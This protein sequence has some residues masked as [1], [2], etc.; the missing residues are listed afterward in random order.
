MNPNRDTVFGEVRAMLQA[1]LPVLWPILIFSAVF[2]V[3]LL[4][5]SFFMLLVYD[6]VLASRSGAT[7]A[8]LLLMVTIAYVFQGAVDVIRSRVLLHSG[9][10]ADQ[11]LCDRLYDIVSRYEQEVGPMPSGAAPVR[12]LDVVRGYITGPGPLALLDLP[13]VIMFL[14]ILTLF[15]WA[16]GLATLAGVLIMIALMVLGDRR[17][18]TPALQAAAV[19]AARFTMAEDVRRNGEVLRVLGMGARRRASWDAVSLNLIAAHDELAGVSGRTQVIGKAFRLF[20]QSFVLAVGA[21]LVIDNDATGGVIIAGSILSARALMPVEQTIG[22]WK[23]MTEAGQAWRRLSALLDQVPPVEPPMPLP[24]PHVGI[25]VQGVV[26]GPPGRQKITVANVSFRL[27]AGEALAV[28]GHSGSGKSSLMRAM[29]GAWPLLRGA[30]RL[31]GA[32]LDQWDPVQIGSDIGY[33]PQAIELFEG[34]IAQNIARFDPQAAP[35]AIIAAARAADVHDMIVALPGGYEYPIGGPTGGGL[36]GG[37][38]QRIALA[39]AL[40]GDPFLIVLDEPNSNL[41]AA[42]EDALLTAIA[43]A[44]QRGA[45]VI[46]VGHRPTVFAQVDHIMIMADG[47]VLQMGERAEMLKRINFS[48][49]P[50]RTPEPPVE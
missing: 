44:K 30:V 22:Q 32:S 15:H 50:S 33:V 17:T 5:G 43:A 14:V 11:K 42:G 3:L 12:D 35:E 4:S 27:S 23:P 37:Q 28:I 48:P 45:L 20:L 26:C 16:L 8:G 31:D 21:F 47:Q 25:E 6:D 2:N 13:Y 41:D 39:R 24:R 49:A 18:R 9:A 29:T 38:K 19:A 46:I 1:I 34:S 40:Y 7:L 36:S 10:Q